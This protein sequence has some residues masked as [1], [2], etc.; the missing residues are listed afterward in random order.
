MV[1]VYSTTSYFTSYTSDSFYSSLDPAPTNFFVQFLRHFLFFELFSITSYFFFFSLFLFSANLSIFSFPVFGNILKSFLL[2]VIVFLRH[3]LDLLQRASFTVYLF[4][5]TSCVFCVPA[6]LLCLILPLD[7]R[8]F[9]ASLCV[10]F[11]FVK[12]LLSVSG[13]AAISPT[14]PT[15][16]RRALQILEKGN[17]ATADCCW[18]CY[19][20][21]AAESTSGLASFSFCWNKTPLISSQMQT[22]RHTNGKTNGQRVGFNVFS[23]LLFLDICVC[24]GVC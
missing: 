5:L 20:R 1:H 12:R 10:T 9:F 24:V 21:L 19:C 6:P 16:A 17:R 15:S 7:S 11:F 13:T 18:C 4:L 22:S 8:E 14:P 3:L 23:F 2:V